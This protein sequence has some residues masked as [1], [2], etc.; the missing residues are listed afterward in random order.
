M[1]YQS[2][3]QPFQQVGED[4]FVTRTTTTS[5]FTTVEEGFLSGNIIR[6]EYRPYKN[7]KVPALNPTNDKE[8]RLYKLMSLYNYLHDLDLY[9]AVY[10]TD[11]E[12][13]KLFL[14]TKPLY[15]KAREDYVS[16]YGPLTD[17]DSLD[18]NGTYSYVLVPSPFLGK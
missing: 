6:N 5:K 16:K 11:K 1:Y 17:T 4:E 13:L 10:P 18:A 12:A 2:F 9:L 7:Y 15:L 3:Y 14:E 8:T